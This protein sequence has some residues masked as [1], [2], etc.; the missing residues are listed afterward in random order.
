MKHAARYKLLI[1]WLL[2][3]ALLPYVIDLSGL[4]TIENA[5]YLAPAIMAAL[6]VLNLIFLRK[7]IKV[8]LTTITLNVIGFILVGNTSIVFAIHP[9]L[10][11]IVLPLI[12]Q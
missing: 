10:K 11:V 6:Q 8:A 1:F 5:Y 12:G 3:N 9:I 2:I 4:L 7:S